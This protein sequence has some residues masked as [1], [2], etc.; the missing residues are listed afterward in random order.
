ML[1]VYHGHI[2]G[3]FFFLLLR[4]D[5]LKVMTIK[6]GFKIHQKQNIC[7]SMVMSRATDTQYR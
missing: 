1:K 4:P 6:I 7:R 2:R 3:I 5:E